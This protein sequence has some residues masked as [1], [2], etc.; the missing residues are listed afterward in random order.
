M[1]LL[2]WSFVHDDSTFWHILMQHSH[3]IQFQPKELCCT[4]MAPRVPAEN[5][6][7]LLTRNPLETTDCGRGV[8]FCRC[9]FLPVSFNSGLKGRNKNDKQAWAFYCV[10]CQSCQHHDWW[11]LCPCAAHRQVFSFFLLWVCLFII[12]IQTERSHMYIQ[13]INIS[14]STLRRWNDFTHPVICFTCSTFTAVW[15]FPLHKH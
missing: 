12:L 14:F 7:I 10:L 2:Y 11:W 1:V 8:P 13:A 3:L 9:W 4:S 6:N 5:I 15:C